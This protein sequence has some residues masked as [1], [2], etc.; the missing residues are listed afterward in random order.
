[1]R[2]STNMDE[3]LV[4]YLEHA[5]KEGAAGKLGQFPDVRQRMLSLPVC[6]KCERIALRETRKS[7]PVRGYITCPV[8]L[9]HGPTTL[10]VS[11]F[12]QEHV[13]KDRRRI[14]SG[15]IRPEGR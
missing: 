8:C 12:V 10:S 11:T 9:Y 15:A 5:Q 4:K 13:V 3:R 7:D 1:M 14:Q 6:P 2:P